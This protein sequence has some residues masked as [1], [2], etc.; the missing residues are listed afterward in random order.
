MAEREGFEPS[1]PAP[2][3]LDVS[4]I[5]ENGE[6]QSSPIASPNVGNVQ[7]ELSE[8]VSAWPSLPEPIRQAVLTLLRAS[9]GGA[10]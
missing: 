5:C 1:P 6:A 4:A 9:R 3:S 10:K 7:Q 2:P 8:I